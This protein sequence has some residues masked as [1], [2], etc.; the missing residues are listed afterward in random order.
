MQYLH[1]TYFRFQPR[2]VPVFLPQCTCALCC[3]LSLKSK[4]HLIGPQTPVTWHGWLNRHTSPARSASAS[5]L[6][7]SVHVG[8]HTF[9]VLFLHL[10]A[11]FRSCT[12]GWQEPE[13]YDT[14]WKLFRLLIWCYFS[15]ILL[16]LWHP[17]LVFAS[18]G[19]DSPLCLILTIKEMSAREWIVN[20]RRLFCP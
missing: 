14:L 3:L 19:C 13:Q 20:G 17:S 1:N 7:L 18:R 4:V 15:S 11:S 5:Y 12:Q 2:L 6:L 9:I 10:F 8:H 16:G